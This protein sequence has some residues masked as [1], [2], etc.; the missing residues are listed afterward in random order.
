MVEFDRHAG[1]EEDHDF[2]LAILF[3]KCEEKKKPLFRWAN[4]ITLQNEEFS[5]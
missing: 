5:F 3:Q 2:F 4:Y 1:T